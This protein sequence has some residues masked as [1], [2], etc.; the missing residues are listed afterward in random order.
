MNLFEVEIV[1][2]DTRASWHVSPTGDLLRT[3]PEISPTFCFEDCETAIETAQ[4]SIGL[5]GP[6]ANIE[7]R[8]TRHYFDNDGRHHSHEF[9]LNRCKLELIRDYDWQYYK[10]AGSTSSMDD[11]DELSIF[12]ALRLIED[13]IVLEIGDQLNLIVPYN[14]GEGAYIAIRKF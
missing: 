1:R 7:L 6:H 13:E 8:I 10:K 11:G 4:E 14:H 5:D 9:D 2:K 3:I 12:E